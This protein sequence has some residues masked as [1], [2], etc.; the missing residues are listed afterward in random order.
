MT[1]IN[2]W[3]TY[4]AP[5]VKELPYFSRLYQEHE[6]D[7]AMLAVH[8]SLVTDDPAEYAADKD[9]AMPVAVDTDD[10]L[11]FDI[12]GGGATLPQTIVLNRRGEVIYNEVRSVTEEMLAALYE[13]ASGD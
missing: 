12:V 13:E 11:V 6:G 10:D 3:A 1:V 8:S 5:C 7:I 2:L 9:W 4:C